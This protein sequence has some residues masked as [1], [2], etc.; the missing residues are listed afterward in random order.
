MV[1]ITGRIGAGKTSAGRYLSLRYGFQYLRYSQV[2][3]EWLAKDSETKARLQEVGWKV[4]A[5]GMQVE[6]NH[7]LVARVNTQAD[8]AVDGLRHPIDC[9]SLKKSFASSFH[10]LYIECSREERSNRLTGHGRYATLDA[11]DTEYGRAKM[12]VTEG[13][14]ADEIR[15]LGIRKTM[16]LTKMSQHTIEKLIRGKA[17]KRKTHEHVL[18]AIQAYKSKTKNEQ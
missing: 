13:P 4:M 15:V 1:G 10:L 14:L 17:V 16:D 2:L 5:G 3:S 12:I 11:F 18:K 7:R 8:A 6:L 9:E